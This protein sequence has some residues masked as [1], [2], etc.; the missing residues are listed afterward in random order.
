VID[1]P[2][3]PLP[4]H[5]T[6]PA[7]ATYD[8]DFYA[9][10]FAA[11]DR[12]F[13][14]RAR[15]RA[16]AALA[17]QITGALAPGYRVLE[18]GC[19]NGNVLAALREAAPRG[20]VVGLDLYIEGLRH[21]RRRTSC[22]LVQGDVDAVPFRARFDLIGLFDVI[23]HLP[24]D[25]GLLRGLHRLLKPGGRLLITVPA[26][27]SLWSYFDEV[28]HHRRRYETDELA[29]TLVTAGYEIEYC[30]QYMMAMFPLVWLRRLT[31]TL[32][33]RPSDPETERRQREM[34]LRELTIV[35]VV[36]RLLD[37][38]LSQEARLLSRRKRLPIGASLVAIAR[39][40]PQGGGP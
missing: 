9:P 18:V 23:E 15:N 1:T 8:A 28:A 19:G 36:N 40:A 34:A 22:P 30:T 14:F 7:S 35:P 5:P 6:V 11:E 31:S 25:R 29:A 20:T 4:A 24:D 33:L 12:H 3:S 10:L 37:F 27:R 2:P 32:R 26:H 21:A 16:I 38:L 17:R 39:Q 13:W